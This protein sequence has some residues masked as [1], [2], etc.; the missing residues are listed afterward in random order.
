MNCCVT[1]KIKRKEYYSTKARKTR[2]RGLMT[3]MP[4]HAVY[5]LTSLVNL[6]P[7]SLLFDVKCSCLSSFLMS[8]VQSGIH[9]SLTQHAFMCMYW[10]WVHV[11]LSKLLSFR[12]LLA[13]GGEDP[14]Q[15]ELRSHGQS[16]GHG[17]WRL[18]PNIQRTQTHHQ[19]HQSL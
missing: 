12:V 7:D 9:P 17:V 4:F 1:F 3:V 18:H 10:R 6:S 13:G 5:K 14:V 15:R 19:C 11:N 8:I 2:E 16:L